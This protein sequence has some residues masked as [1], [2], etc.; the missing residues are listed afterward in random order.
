MH[1]SYSSSRFSSVLLPMFGAPTMDTKPERK[2]RK[3]GAEAGEG[4]LPGEEAGEGGMMRPPYERGSEYLRCCC[5]AR[6]GTGSWK[7][8]A[9]SSERATASRL[10]RVGMFGREGRGLQRSICWWVLVDAGGR[11]EGAATEAW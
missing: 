7:E 4:G 1:S 8:Q 10:S 9:E 11:R 6:E 3:A 2:G 5:A